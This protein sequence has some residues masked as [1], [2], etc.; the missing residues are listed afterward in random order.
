MLY[1]TACSCT[2]DAHSVGLPGLQALKNKVKYRLFSVF[3]KSLMHLDAQQRS[4]GYGLLW[5][6]KCGP[7]VSQ[8]QLLQCPQAGIEDSAGEGEDSLGCGNSFFA[9]QK[10]NF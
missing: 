7:L 10:A 6:F 5:C 4:Q 9:S 3:H 1:P 2:K 8:F